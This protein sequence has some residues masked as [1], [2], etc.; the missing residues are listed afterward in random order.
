MFLFECLSLDKDGWYLTKEY[1]IILY[2]SI[3]TMITWKRDYLKEAKT[4]N[5]LRSAFEPLLNKG[6]YYQE[7]QDHIQLTA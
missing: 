1:L 5:F 3:H 2:N 4:Y 6:G 7:C